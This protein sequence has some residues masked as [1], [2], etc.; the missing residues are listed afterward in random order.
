MIITQILCTSCKKVIPADAYGPFDRD[1]ML[2]AVQ[3]S[4]K[5][6]GLFHQR[7]DVYY[8]IWPRDDVICLREGHIMKVLTRRVAHNG[9]SISGLASQNQSYRRV[10]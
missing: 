7:G 10:E 9:F 6:V 3:E 4:P 2:K 1:Q 5:L 8:L